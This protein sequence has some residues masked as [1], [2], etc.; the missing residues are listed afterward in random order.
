M[1]QNSLQ[2]CNIALIV[3]TDGDEK[4]IQTLFSIIDYTL[5]PLKV[6]TLQIFFN[7]ISNDKETNTVK[8]NV[9]GQVMLVFGYNLES[10]LM[11]LLQIIMHG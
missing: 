7:E 9:F 2:T 1:T 6:P 10:T 8:L 3:E 11:R 5:Q 4:I